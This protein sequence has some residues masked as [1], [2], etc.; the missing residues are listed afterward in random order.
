MFCN[1]TNKFLQSNNLDVLALKIFMLDSQTTVKI[2]LCETSQHTTNTV[3]SW[4]NYE[5]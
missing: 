3:T 1:Q 5:F 4:K 2:I